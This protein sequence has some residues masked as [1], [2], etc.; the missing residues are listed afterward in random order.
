MAMKVS[1]QTVWAATLKDKPG[2]VTGKLA[3]LADA[4]ADLD[5]VIARRTDQKKGKG[6][7]FVTPLAGAKQ[8]AAA[9]KAGFRRAARMHGL[10]V[11]ATDKPGLGAKLTAAVAETG[12]NLR[13]LSAASIGRRCV[14]N[15]SFDKAAD[16]TQ[17][18]RAIRKIR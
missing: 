4:G 16:A 13:G 9:R 17:A 6:V 7:L 10:C 14:C 12:I 2:S 1:R 5:F 8:I 11:E 3:K 15:L 18:A